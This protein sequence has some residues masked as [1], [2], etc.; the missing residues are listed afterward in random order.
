VLLFPKA[1]LSVLM[2][3]PQEPPAP[4]YPPNKEYLLLVVQ[5][6]PVHQQVLTSAGQNLLFEPLDVRFAGNTTSC[7]IG[8]K[9]LSASE[10]I[11]EQNKLGK[12]NIEK[13]AKLNLSLND[14]T[15]CC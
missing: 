4:A 6:S 11:K 5:L 2:P 14:I 8:S 12:Q 7:G 15:Y 10:K 13:N 1:F 9:T 3:P